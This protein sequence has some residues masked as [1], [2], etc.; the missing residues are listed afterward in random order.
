MSDIPA[1]EISENDPMGDIPRFSIYSDIEDRAVFP[2]AIGEW[3]RYE[4][5]AAALAE[6]KAW[7]LGEMVV[8]SAEG[9]ERARR[10][11][12]ER[13][14]G[15]FIDGVAKGIADEKKRAAERVAALR[16]HKRRRGIVLV[17]SGGEHPL[18][19]EGG[20]KVLTVDRDEAVAA[21]RGDA[22]DKVATDRQGADLDNLHDEQAL[23]DAPFGYEQ[24]PDD[25]LIDGGD[26]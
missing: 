12:E 10:E 6:E 8:A 3:V 17:F 14:V 9:Y 23:A 26:S 5:H 15:H 2:S 1:P 7:A 21:A 24:Q 22:T 20:D 25:Y 13:L 19:P 4:E 16:T 18:R 11:Y